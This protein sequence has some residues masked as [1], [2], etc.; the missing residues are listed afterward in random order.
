MLTLLF[1]LVVLSLAANALLLSGSLNFN[2]GPDVLEQPSP[3]NT[4]GR[5]TQRRKNI[6]LL[7]SIF[8]LAGANMV[9]AL[10]WYGHLKFEAWPLSFA[11]LV[12]WFLALPEYILQ[13]SANR[14]GYAYLT[15]SHLK[16]LQLILTTCAFLAF[17]VFYFDTTLSWKEVLGLGLVLLGAA[18]ILLKP[19]LPACP[20]QREID[21]A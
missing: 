13:I 9:M 1:I 7:T 4:L 6:N 5:R 12:S 20:E 11:I 15:A 16:T 21:N 2:A 8:L 17:V 3:S 14:I 18:V 10:A 19:R